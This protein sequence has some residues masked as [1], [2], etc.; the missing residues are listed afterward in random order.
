VNPF[1]QGVPDKDVTITI[2][3]ECDENTAIVYVV[4]A[5]CIGAVGVLLG[6][7]AIQGH[8]SLATETVKAGAPCVAPVAPVTKP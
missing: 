1:R 7:Y 4:A 2:K 3:R 6:S 5:L 8:Y